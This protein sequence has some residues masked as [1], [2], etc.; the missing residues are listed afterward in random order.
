MSTPSPP[1]TPYFAYM[2][3]TLQCMNDTYLFLL[4]DV[5]AMINETDSRWFYLLFAKWFML[6]HL[7]DD[8]NE[9]TAAQDMMRTALASTSRAKDKELANALQAVVVAESVLANHSEAIAQCEKLLSLNTRSPESCVPPPYIPI[10]V[11][12][13]LYASV[14]GCQSALYAGRYR[15]YNRLFASSWD[16]CVMLH[17]RR[18]ILHLCLLQY[19]CLQF[20]N[21]WLLHHWTHL[22]GLLDQFEEISNTVQVRAMCDVGGALR[23]CQTVAV[24]TVLRATQQWR[25]LG[26]CH[27]CGRG[28]PLQRQDPADGMHT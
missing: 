3:R 22:S 4:R 15:A 12:P 28:K 7:V 20:A 5:L 26:L 2:P 21:A 16:T 1:L 9:L 6:G 24:W 19:L 8:P 14:Y 25:K 18:P 27:A 13:F 23:P 11:H 10:Y 17:T